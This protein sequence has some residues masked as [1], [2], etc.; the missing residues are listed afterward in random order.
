MMLSIVS[1]NQ[2]IKCD[3]ELDFSENDNVMF[4]VVS[5]VITL[6]SINCM[7]KQKSHQSE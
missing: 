7:R 5:V 6:E 4:A 1:C 2:Y 3:Y